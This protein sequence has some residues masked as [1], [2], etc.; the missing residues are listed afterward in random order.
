MSVCASFW[1]HAHVLEESLIG[2]E[3]GFTVMTD[4]GAQPAT[5]AARVSARFCSNCGTALQGKFCSAC[6]AAAVAA[7]PAEQPSEGW[8]S[9]TSE[10]MSSHGRNG[11]FSVALSFLRHPVDT[12]IRLTDDPTYRSQWGFLTATVGAQL[13]LAYVVLPRLFST[14]FNLPSVANS[15]GVLRDEIV[16]YVGMAVLTPIQFY[17]CRAL[18]T[19]R[20]S[21]MSYVKLCVLS[22]SFG[23]LLSILI[24]VFF[25]AIAVVLLK[26]AVA[27]DLATLWQGVSMMALVGVLVFV[28]MS[29]Q[30]FWGMKWAIAIGVTLL[31]AALSWLVVYPGISALIERGGIVGAI[32]S[33]TGG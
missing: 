16:Q 17:I 24:S 5:G 28:A 12:I 13:T 22:I 6:G 11:I 2:R 9:L 15:S 30:R 14:I 26:N 8:G 7:A 20:R 29:H 19:R 10:F 31:F 23:A 25:F 32:S 27:V 4:S 1:R 3:R 18:G 33:L 21:P